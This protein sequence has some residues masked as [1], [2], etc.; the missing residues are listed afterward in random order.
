MMLDGLLVLKLWTHATLR[1]YW[2][3]SPKG[4][5][6]VSYKKIKYLDG[7][8]INLINLEKDNIDKKQLEKK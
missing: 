1:K 3:G 2:F 6:I 4:L 8:K 5:L 7:Y